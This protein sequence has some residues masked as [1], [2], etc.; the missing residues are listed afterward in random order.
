MKKMYYIVAL[1]L[2]CSCNTKNVKNADSA[3]ADAANDSIAET[4][5]LDTEE[6]IVARV[7]EIYS[8]GDNDQDVFSASFRA[9]MDKVRKYDE[10]AELGYIDHDILTQAQD[11]VQVIDIRVQDITPSTATATVTTNFAVLTVRLVKESNLWMVDDVNT[12]RET[13]MKYMAE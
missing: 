13:M 9:L 3:A 10:G 4:P 1:A 11:N 2:V 7:R 6:V 8:S 12:E 5:A